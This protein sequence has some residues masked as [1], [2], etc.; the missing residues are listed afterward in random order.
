MRKY[1][2]VPQIRKI[3]RAARVVHVAVRQKNRLRCGGAIN[4]SRCL[5]DLVRV[6]RGSRVYQRP[7]P[8]RCADEVNV[9]DTDL[10]PEDVLCDLLQRHN[11]IL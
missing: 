4:R 2:N 6:L 8:V 9:G 3:Q 5:P 1:R 11:T 10:Q 7:R